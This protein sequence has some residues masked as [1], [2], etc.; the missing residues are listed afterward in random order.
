[1]RRS[2]ASTTQ[3]HAGPQQPGILSILSAPVLYRIAGQ[4]SS[5]TRSK[6][7]AS[8]QATTTRSPGATETRLAADESLASTV[9]SS[10]LV[11]EVVGVLLLI[12]STSVSL[13]LLWGWPSKSLQAHVKEL[14][15][16]G[17]PW[18]A[19]VEY[20]LDQL[21]QIIPQFKGECLDDFALNAMIPKMKRT[22]TIPMH[23]PFEN[24]QWRDGIPLLV[25]SGE[26]EVISGSWYATGKILTEVGHVGETRK[27]VEQNWKLAFPVRRRITGYC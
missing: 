19:Q 21:R 22:R 9:V 11:V 20:Q 25:E 2:L 15:L 6:A 14:S 8:R 13:S 4:T 17:T 5:L 24:F 7:S 26:L 3:S 10:S 18:H 12:L 16:S 1:M 23:E 27:S